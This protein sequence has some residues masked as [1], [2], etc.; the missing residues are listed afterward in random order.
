MYFFYSPC[1]SSRPLLSSSSTGNVGARDLHMQSC[2]HRFSSQ[3]VDGSASCGL[4]ALGGERSRT[5]PPLLHFLLLFSISFSSHFIFVF[6]FPYC[7]LLQHCG[8]EERQ[9]SSFSAR[10]LQESFPWGLSSFFV[11]SKS[12]GVGAFPPERFFP[13]PS[14][15]TR[16]R[17]SFP[18]ELNPSIFL[19]FSR[20][21]LILHPSLLKSMDL[22]RFE[23]R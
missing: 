13:I 1:L 12:T 9:V 18:P 15:Q 8:D 23:P 20:R 5:G 11:S 4:T 17:H 22:A 6:C 10:E 21:G 7:W 19:R 3:G 2:S 14:F 16:A